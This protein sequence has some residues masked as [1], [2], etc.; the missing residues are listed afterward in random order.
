MK[1]LSNYRFNP[2]RSVLA[3]LALVA[4]A[5]PTVNAPTAAARATVAARAIEPLHL[6]LCISLPISDRRVV[7]VVGGWVAV[8]AGTRRRPPPGSA[9]PRDTPPRAS[10][11]AVG[12]VDTAH[13][14]NV[15]QKEQ[16]RQAL[17]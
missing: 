10:G 1:L 9:S 3:A 7:A 17:A 5:A 12:S 8:D 2:R 6:S 13:N 16:A 15:R 4:S 11:R 14:D